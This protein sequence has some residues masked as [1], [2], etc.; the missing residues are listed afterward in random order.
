MTIFNPPKFVTRSL[1]GAVGLSAIAFL[2][3]PES[4]SA[5]VVCGL[6]QG[7]FVQGPNWV[8]ECPEGM[9]LFPKS[10][11]ILDIWLLNP[12]GSMGQQFDNLMFMGPAKITREEGSNGIILTQISETLVAEIPGLG[13][14]TLTG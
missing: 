1:I 12:D 7:S 6:N 11:A 10:W 14:L 3:V 5:N 4:A 2:G 8:S 13:P 9:D